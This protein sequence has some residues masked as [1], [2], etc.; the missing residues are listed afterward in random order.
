MNHDE[1]RERYNQLITLIRGWMEEDDSEPESSDA[2]TLDLWV[3]GPQQCGQLHFVCEAINREGFN[4][5]EEMLL[6]L[7]IK[8]GWFLASQVRF[9]RQPSR[10]PG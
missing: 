1:R 9:F 8:Y 4:L 2:P 7:M 6:D 10:I 3:P 5:T